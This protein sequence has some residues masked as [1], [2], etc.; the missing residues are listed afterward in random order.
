MSRK[1]L[2]VDDEQHIL[3]TIRAYL[4]S[5]G[6]EVILAR[7]GQQALFTFR[8]EKPDLIVLDIMMPEMDGLEAARLIRKESSVPIIFLTARVEDMDQITGLELGADEY[9]TKP[10][11]PRVLVARIRALLRRAYGDLAPQ[12]PVWR[13]GDLE[14]NAETHTVTRAGQRIELTPTEFDLLVALVSRPGRVFSR[15]ELL[16]RLDDSFAAYERAVDVHIK[17]LRAKI[18]IDS[19]N[20]E[21]IETVY[22][23]GYRMRPADE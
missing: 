9:I 18:E 22:G 8:H 19:R 13:V 23:V 4:S 20:P 17:N 11:G 3:D 1:I 16:D 5:E 7:D 2:I 12:A 10:F 14:V 6:Y 15:A 21:Y